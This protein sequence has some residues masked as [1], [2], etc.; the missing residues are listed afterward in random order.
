MFLIRR[1]YKTKPGEA[2]KVATLGH[3]ACALLEEAGQRRDSRV[4][5]NPGT[6]PGEKNIVV[7]EWVDDAIQSVFR[8]ENEMP[9]DAMALAR[10][11][12]PL[13]EDSWIEF[14]ELLTPDKMVD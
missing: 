13:V 6:T 11:I 4:Y 7:L 8:G 14:S 2:R 1:V 10:Q 9:E 3:K 12:P 5:F